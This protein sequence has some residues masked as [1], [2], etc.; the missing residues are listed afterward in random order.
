MLT[1]QKVMKVPEF[2]VYAGKDHHNTTQI[3]GCYISGYIVE[4]NCS[5]HILSLEFE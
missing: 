3:W 2:E 5:N 4:I 1:P